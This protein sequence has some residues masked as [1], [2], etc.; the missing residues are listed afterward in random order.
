MPCEDIR[1]RFLKTINGIK[2]FSVDASKMRKIKTDFTIGSNYLVDKIIPKNQIYIDNK[3]R[4]LDRKAIIKH[5]VV[6]VAKMAKGVPYKTAHAYA[7]KI[8]R[9]FRKKH[10]VK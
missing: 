2:I 9:M 6:E 5:E 10:E 3:L 8:E 1:K 7:T 4:G